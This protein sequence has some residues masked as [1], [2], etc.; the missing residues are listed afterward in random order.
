MFAAPSLWT[1]STIHR[2]LLRSGRVARGRIVSLS[3]IYMPSDDGLCRKILLPSEECWVIT[4]VLCV[5]RQYAFWSFSA[6]LSRMWMN[7]R[8]RLSLRTWLA[9]YRSS[10]FLPDANRVLEIVFSHRHLH[11]LL[12]QQ[13]IFAAQCYVER[14]IAAASRP[15][16]RLLVRTS[17][18]LKYRDHIGWKSSKLIHG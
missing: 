13:S 11:L 9:Y 6:T 18:T 5:I 4:E 3:V 16:V 12:F 1:H 2:E 14:G 7:C 17:V 10:F 8:A 15:S